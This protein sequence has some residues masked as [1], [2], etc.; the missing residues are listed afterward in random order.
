VACSFVDG[1]FIACTNVPGNI[2]AGHFQQSNLY[3]FGTGC[4]A[5]ANSTGCASTPTSEQDTYVTNIQIWTCNTSGNTYC[6]GS[7]LVNGPPPALHYWH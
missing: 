4:N 1:N 3:S 5:N 2:A 7:T 6:N